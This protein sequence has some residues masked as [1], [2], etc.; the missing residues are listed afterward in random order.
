MF[1]TFVLYAKMHLC[2]KLGPNIM[3]GVVEFG[4]LV[5]KSV[6]CAHVMCQFA[7]RAHSSNDTNC[8][9]KQ[10]HATLRN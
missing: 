3:K 4:D 2:A 1:T 10:Q 6:L 8:S 9:T 7:C 5:S